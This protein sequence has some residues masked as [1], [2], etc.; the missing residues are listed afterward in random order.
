[1]VYGAMIKYPNNTPVKKRRDT[2]NIT[3]RVFLSSLAVS[4][5]LVNFQ[6]CQKT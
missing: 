4:A 2:Q 5:G 1:M 3:P 6:N